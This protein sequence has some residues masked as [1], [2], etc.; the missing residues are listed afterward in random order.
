MSPKYFLPNLSGCLTFTLHLLLN[1]TIC[2]SAPLFSQGIMVLVKFFVTEIPWVMNWAKGISCSVHGFY[3][4]VIKPSMI[5][6]VNI[7]H[8][9]EKD[10][11]AN[12][13]QSNAIR[14]TPKKT[15]VPFGKDLQYAASN[16]GRFLSGQCLC[17]LHFSLCYLQSY[18]GQ[19]GKDYLCF[20]VSF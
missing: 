14:S 20:R 9:I 10:A 12:G 5:W 18:F 19:Q 6:K 15:M 16:N 1:G 11:V 8:L 2:S 17:L 13:W 3:C 7:N 4:F